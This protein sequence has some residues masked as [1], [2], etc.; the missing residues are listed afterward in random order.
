MKTSTPIALLFSLSLATLALAQS[1]DLQTWT[2]TKG[3]VIQAKFIKLQGDSVTL[4]VNGREFVFPIGKLSPE[5]VALA[6]K[7]AG[8]A[9]APP[10]KGDV[11]A[12]DPVS[13]LG[14]TFEQCEAVLGKPEKVE[15]PDGQWRSFARYYK[16]SVPGISRIKLER[17]PEGS[18]S[19]P[20]P[21]T[22]NSV[23][24]YFP[25]G[26]L[27][28]MGEV[29]AKLGLAK[30]GAKISTGYSSLD[31][32]KAAAKARGPK[33]PN[34][35]WDDPLPTEPGI[36]QSVSGIKGNL[37]AYWT[38]AES[39]KTR[40]P[41]FQHP[42]ED[43]LKI[44]ED[45]NIKFGTA[46]PAPPLAIN[47]SPELR[48]NG[49]FGFPQASA[50]VL[51]DEKEFRLSV[52]SNAEW[53]YVQ[54]VIWADGE[55][56]NLPKTGDFSTLFLDLDADRKDTPGLDRFY[57]LETAAD[58]ASTKPGLS[59]RVLADKPSSD[60]KDD[61]QGRGDVRFEPAADG[62]KVRVDSYLIP[63]AELGR[64]PGDS[65]RLIL[66]GWSSKPYFFFNSAALREMNGRMTSSLPRHDLWHDF[67]LG[68]Q[69]G[70][71]DPALVPDG[72]QK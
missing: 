44:S 30:D 22:V 35:S 57:R 47:D 6:K 66:I 29:F 26:T 59:Y 42:D 68:E 39:S 41:R 65:I 5:S 56:A 38:S 11:K 67:T 10:V 21:T 63:L 16:S 2:D 15:E 37:V 23:I 69:T 70:T 40:S 13:W 24:C 62:K 18:M 49:A 53:L 60:Q 33:E 58:G 71:I 7:L 64:K 9:D 20:V 61:S 1:S 50:K 54:A 8:V 27:K 72:R 55:A 45:P 4:D 17:L 51:R 28:T 34:E 3:K 19:G 52:W 31:A 36:S 32:A 14:K 25:K 43:A 48:K 12:N 46:K